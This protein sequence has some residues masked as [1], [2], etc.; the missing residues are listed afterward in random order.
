MR[1][2]MPEVRLTGVDGNNR[3]TVIAFLRVSEGLGMAAAP[4]RAKRPI[5]SV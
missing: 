5:K 4:R 2:R 1:L 3:C